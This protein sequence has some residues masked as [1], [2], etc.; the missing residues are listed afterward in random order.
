[1]DGVSKSEEKQRDDILRRML[2]T[3]PT[4]H[5]PIGNRKKRDPAKRDDAGLSR[6]ERQLWQSPLPKVE[7][8]DLRPGAWER[9]EHAAETK[10]PAAPSYE[11]PQVD[12]SGLA[13]AGAALGAAARRSQTEEANLQACMAQRGYNLAAVPPAR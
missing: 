5:K 3:P 4:P 9:F 11:A 13:D 12:F 8:S 1:V 7:S 2:K 10:S 6:G